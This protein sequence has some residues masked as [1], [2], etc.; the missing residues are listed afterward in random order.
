MFTLNTL[1]RCQQSKH[2]FGSGPVGDL[3]RVL[4][5]FGMSCE[6]PC[7]LFYAVYAIA[8]VPAPLTRSPV[9]T[10]KGKISFESWAPV[11][12]VGVVLL[13]PAD[14]RVG[15]LLQFRYQWRFLVWRSNARGWA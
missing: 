7:V 9:C 8:L 12:L 15:R 2:E 10:A 4:Q 14:F 3:A 13:N 5:G 11:M 1:K 6:M